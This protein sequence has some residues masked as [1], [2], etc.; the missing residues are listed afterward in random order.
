MS[1][2]TSIR[3]HVLD[4]LQYTPKSILE[5]QEGA[6]RK[7]FNKLANK[8]GVLDKGAFLGFCRRCQISPQLISR[9]EIMEIYKATHYDEMQK[10]RR[11]NSSIG[12]G[13]STTSDNFLLNSRTT[14]SF[15]KSK[16]NNNQNGELS[17]LETKVFNYDT[18]TKVGARGD[19]LTFYGWVETL[20]RSAGI[21]FSGDEWEETYPTETDKIRLLLFWI[22][23]GESTSEEDARVAANRRIPKTLTL[24]HNKRRSSL[25]Q[26]NNKF[27]VRKTS[28]V[29]PRDALERAEA[30]TQAFGVHDVR[31]SV[32]AFDV[33][34]IPTRFPQLLPHVESLDVELK[35]LFIWYAGAPAEYPAGTEG[36]DLEMSAARFYKFVRECRILSSRITRG[37]IDV[38]FKKVTSAMHKTIKQHHHNQ[39]VNNGWKSNSFTKAACNQRKSMVNRRMNYEDFYIALADLATRKYAPAT[40]SPNI[41][42][43]KGNMVG[44]AFHKLLLHDVLP[45]FARFWEKTSDTGTAI[46]VGSQQHQQ[47]LQ[48]VSQYAGGSP[49]KRQGSW[50]RRWVEVHQLE[51]ELRRSDVVKAFH[52]RNDEIMQLL[53]APSIKSFNHRIKQK[54]TMKNRSVKA[55]NMKNKNIMTNNREGRALSTTRYEEVK[56]DNN[57][58][59]DSSLA[60][61]HR[62]ISRKLSTTSLAGVYLTQDNVKILP[63]PPPPPVAPSFSTAMNANT[64]PLP[65]PSSS[66]SSPFRSTANLQQMQSLNNSSSNILMQSVASTIAIESEKD[67]ELQNILSVVKSKIESLQQTVGNTDVK[68]NDIATDDR[69]RADSALTDDSTADFEDAKPMAITSAEMDTVIRTIIESGMPV[70]DKNDNNNIDTRITNNDKIEEKEDKSYVASPTKSRTNKGNKKKKKMTTPMRIGDLSTDSPDV[71]MRSKSPSSRRSPK[72]R[73]ARRVNKRMSKKA[74]GDVVLYETQLLNS[75]L[76]ILQGKNYAR[77]GYR[78][79]RREKRVEYTGTL[80]IRLQC[81]WKATNLESYRIIITSEDDSLFHFRHYTNREMFE[82]IRQRHGFQ[83]EFNKYPEVLANVFDEASNTLNDEIDIRFAARRDGTAAFTIS[84]NLYNGAKTINILSLNFTQSSDRQ[85][86]QDRE[87]HQQQKSRQKTNKSK[88]TFSPTALDKTVVNDN[89]YNG[90][91]NTQLGKTKKSMKR[92]RS[93]GKMAGGAVV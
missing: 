22:E 9:A 57:E 2:N 12:L 68:D 24:N 54:K 62:L 70:S 82:G 61:T 33:G 30:A 63:P 59:L 16:N 67:R 55:T 56:I 77:D 45:M 36:D 29:E 23:Q 11:A 3:Q 8:N 75:K 64:L 76:I 4:E 1:N 37:I 40:L 72:S 71:L 14:T 52:L 66:S 6:L 15:I 58:E 93:T 41:S 69:G 39:P 92:R 10:I 87:R 27:L 78:L 26:G 25:F 18:N 47:L 44:A 42:N 81:K 32:A 38:V 43:N 21:L 85:R 13:N 34:G 48:Q 89:G 19:C 65:P 80:D 51:D 5:E 74:N 50:R 84:K 20:R 28:G 46:T 49:E 73:S 53:K 86:D 83:V 31:F 60:T 7:I 91:S 35:R 17:R 90:G 88:V 79:P